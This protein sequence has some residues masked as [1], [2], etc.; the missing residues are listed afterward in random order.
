MTTKNKTETIVY[1][2]GFD[3]LGFHIEDQVINE[4]ENISIKFIPFKSSISLDTADGLVIPQGI[5]EEIKYQDYGSGTYTDFKLHKELMLEREREVK[6]LL[7]DDKWV[8][9]L[10]RGIIDEIPQGLERQKIKHTDLCKIILNEYGIGRLKFDGKP[11]SP[12]KNE[13]LDYIR[14]YGVSRTFFDIPVQLRDHISIIAIY[15][16][17]CAGFELDNSLFFLPFHTTRFDDNACK[18][19]ATV[20]VESILDYRQKNIAEIPECIKSFE[21]EKEVEYKSKITDLT[22]QIHDI[23]QQLRPLESYKLIV[24]TSGDL[25]KNVLVD[26]LENFFGFKVDPIDEGREDAKILDGYGNVIAVVEIKGTNKGIKR[27]HVNQ[28][29]SHRERNAFTDEVPGVLFINNEMDIEGIEERLN[30][31]VPSEQIKHAVNMNV[32]IVRTIDLLFLMKHLES[33]PSKRE[34]VIELINSGGG[35][36]KADR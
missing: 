2:Y 25:L 29:D 6:N 18:S 20:L 10:V 5:F 31:K 34:R 7:S 28:V 24:N 22:N 8:C 30:T 26:I 35:W 14:E 27:E 17:Y 1:A 19:I 32:L 11:S 15:D 4:S 12:S 21:L 36:L 13:F 23:E 16:E 3:R 9:F 33:D